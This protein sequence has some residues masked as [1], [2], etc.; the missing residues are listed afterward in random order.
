MKRLPLKS[1]V[2]TGRFVVPYRIY[3]NVGP[4]IICLNGVQQSMAM[5]H[6][7]I[8]Y[9][10]FR[11]RIVLFDFPGQ[12]KGQILSGSNLVSLDEQ[13]DILHAVI[14]NTHSNNDLTICTASW[15]GVV[16]VAFA[17]KYPQEV[18][19]LNLASLGTKANQ[20]MMETIKRGVEIDMEDRDKMAD[21]LIDSFGQGLPEKIRRKII[22][23]FK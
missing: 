18:K 12:G 8:R 23:Q 20:K 1:K 11:Y 19:R 6:S 15:G 10:S 4:H 5:W 21:T 22:N 2:K 9:F 7:F 16:A 3:D 17:A 14:K 13:V